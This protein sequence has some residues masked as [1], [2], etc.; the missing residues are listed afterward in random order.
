MFELTINNQV[1]EFSFDMG[2]MREVNKRIGVPVDNLPNVKKN[3]GLQYAIASI[4]DGDVEGLVDVLDTANRGRNPRVTK[5]LLDSY[6]DNENTDI[7]QLF[8]DVLNF[9]KKANA[10]KKTMLELLERI[11]AEKAAAA[12]K[13]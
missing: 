2:F 10:T 4:I 9:L 5:A 13:Q 6:I 12:A 8:D 7:D 1:Y 3:V 11:E